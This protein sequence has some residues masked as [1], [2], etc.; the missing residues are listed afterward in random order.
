MKKV[1]VCLLVISSL[2]MF[3]KIDRVSADQ[4]K[5]ESVT[6]KKTNDVFQDFI[7]NAPID[8]IDVIQTSGDVISKG[9]S[10]EI[11]KNLEHQ[12]YETVLRGLEEHGLSLRYIEDNI[13]PML[14]QPYS[15][16][17]TVNRT[18]HVYH[19]EY[20]NT[21][22]FRK[23]WSTALKIS[24][25]E[26]SNGTFTALG[27]PTVNVSANF[28]AAFTEEVSNISTGYRY[29]S[30]NR[31]IDFYAS[32]RMRGRVVIPIEIGGVEIPLGKWYD[33]GYVN[34]TYKLR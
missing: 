16:G 12:N 22:K 2:F 26:N 27:N 10:M 23:E 14:I 18:V 13:N 17:S 9:I 19:L 20:D 6:V 15:I 7:E 24:Y 25:R 1:A 31:G 28:G 34:P 11:K 32:Y 8:D 33:W 5:T 29:T 3:M 30:G 21:K 4:L